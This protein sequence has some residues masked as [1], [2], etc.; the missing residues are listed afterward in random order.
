MAMRDRPAARDPLVGVE[1]RQAGIQPEEAELRMLPNHEVEL[2]VDDTLQVMRAIEAIE[3]LDDVQSVHSNL[4]ISED[5]ITQ[6][7]MA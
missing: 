7:E 5:A 6:L 3:E 1:L 2:D 4:Q